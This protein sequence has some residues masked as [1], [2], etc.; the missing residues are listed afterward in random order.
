VSDFGFRAMALTFKIR[1]FFRP[2]RD[3]VEEVGIKE[4]FH[5]L[6]YGCG[7]GSYVAAVAELTGKSGKIHALDV[8]P[9]AIEIVK[10]IVAKRRLTN[11][12]TI[13]SDRET[14]LPSDSVD[15]VLLYDVFHGLTDPNGV[16]AELHRVLKPG[17]ILPFSD[18]R[19]KENDIVSNLTGKALF[20]FLRKGEK[21]YSFIK[22]GEESRR[23]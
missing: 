19:M 22:A 7:S 20:K 21:T 17:G 2:R 5:V 6:D 14:G 1:D 15:V 12:E 16:L 11:V 18:H 4:G 8:H 3:I 10:K 9:L 13:I 23:K